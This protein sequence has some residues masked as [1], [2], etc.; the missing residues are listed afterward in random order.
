MRMSQSVSG[1]A[2]SKLQPTSAQGQLYRSSKVSPTL[3]QTDLRITDHRG[4]K[5]SRSFPFKLE[6][7]GLQV[8]HN[9][10]FFERI[11]TTPAMFKATSKFFSSLG[12]SDDKN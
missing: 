1:T 7:N 2:A 12:C 8:Y 6:L 4:H 3:F 9:R 11:F 5:F 10:K